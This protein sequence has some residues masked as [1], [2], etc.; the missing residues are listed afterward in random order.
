MKKVVWPALAGGAL[1][2]LSNVEAATL[3]PSELEKAVF[4]SMTLDPDHSKSRLGVRILGQEFPK[5]D[6]ICDAIAEKLL[7]EPPIPADGVALD[8]M[9][10]YIVTIRERCSGRYHDA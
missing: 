2:F 1:L 10:W 7:K 8:A 3:A 6:S 5:D 9:Q 4:L